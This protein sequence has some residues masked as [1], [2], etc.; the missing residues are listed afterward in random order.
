MSP[1]ERFPSGIGVHLRVVAAPTPA[2]APAPAPVAPSPAPAP[3][4]NCGCITGACPAL[5]TAYC[6]T[7]CGC[8]CLGPGGTCNGC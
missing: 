8:V 6:C 3:A 4:V 1:L 7:F 2:P 5:G